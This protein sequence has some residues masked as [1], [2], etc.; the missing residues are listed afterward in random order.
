LETN[1]IR[2]SLYTWTTST[3]FWIC[4]FCSITLR[5]TTYNIIL[6]YRAR[7]NLIHRHTLRTIIL[8]WRMLRVHLFLTISGITFTSYIMIQIYFSLTFTILPELLDMQLEFHISLKLHKSIIFMKIEGERK[9]ERE[10]EKL[11]KF[12]K[13]KNRIMR[14]K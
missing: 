2:A 3:C 7:N 12:L 5:I 6:C 13:R 8:R 14:T 9:K 4:K 11:F 10:R 1:A